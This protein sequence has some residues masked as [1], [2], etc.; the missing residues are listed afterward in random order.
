VQ[1]TDVL[2]LKQFLKQDGEILSRKVTGLCKKQQRKLVIIAKHAKNAGL[3][4]NLTKSALN[5][6]RSLVQPKIKAPMHFHTYFNEYEQM[7]KT[8]KFL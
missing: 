3:T 1:H 8:H 2:I 7:K 5:S 4:S 6:D